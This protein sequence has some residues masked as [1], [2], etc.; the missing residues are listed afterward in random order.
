MKVKTKWIYNISPFSCMRLNS[1]CTD[2]WKDPPS[3]LGNNYLLN[4]ELF[5]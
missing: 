4:K 2:P 5:D 3:L 1:I